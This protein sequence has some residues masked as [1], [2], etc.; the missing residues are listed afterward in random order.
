MFVYVVS[1]G[2]DRQK[3]GKG[4]DPEERRRL[5][6]TGSS[7]P[8]TL[9]H[10][11]RVSNALGVEGLAHR[12]LAGSR[13]HGEWFATSQERAVEAVRSAVAALGAEVA[14][15]ELEP[16]LP[17]KIVDEAGL[18]AR[19]KSVRAYHA[20]REAAGLKKVTLWLSP[21]ARAALETMKATYGSKDAAAEA[22]ILALLTGL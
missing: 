3:I 22:A 12:N 7:V 13:L 2:D 1:A 5:L 17:R 11:Q 19:R 14:P 15:P 20:K 16:H 9:V 6:Q 10:K 21:E 8:L 18:E 4:R